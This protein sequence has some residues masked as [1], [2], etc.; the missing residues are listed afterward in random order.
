VATSTIDATVGGASANSYCTLAEAKQYVEDRYVGSS[1]AWSGASDNDLNQALLF[2]T[3][4]IE[5]TIIFTGFVKTDT[6]ALLWPRYGMTKRNE[7][8]LA[9]DIIPQELKDCESEFA[10]GL[11]V[12]VSRTDDSD[13]ET[14]GIRNLK[15]GPVA[16]TFDETAALKLIPDLAYLYLPAMWIES[17]RGRVS[18]TR[19]LVRTY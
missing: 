16:I 17:T 11:I 12:D 3:R 2:S 9:D 6:Q 5:S 18:A 8:A 4:I 7:Y 13:P 19:T 10:R 15:A 1:T 14:Q